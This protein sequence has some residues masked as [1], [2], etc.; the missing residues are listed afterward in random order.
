MFAKL[1]IKFCLEEGSKK[2]GKENEFQKSLALF[3]KQGID[4]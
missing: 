4:E 2:N 1:S 3:W